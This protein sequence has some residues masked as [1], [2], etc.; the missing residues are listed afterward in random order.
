MA[1]LTVSTVSISGSAVTTVRDASGDGQIYLNDAITTNFYLAGMYNPSSVKS[2]DFDGNG[3]ISNK[4]AT[5]LAHY[6]MQLINGSSV[7]DS[8]LPAPVSADT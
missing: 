4:D 5:V 8:N 2:F 1:V 3:I 7:D 6:W